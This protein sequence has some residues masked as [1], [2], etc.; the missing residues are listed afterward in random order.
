MDDVTQFVIRHANLVLFAAVFADQ[1]GLPFPSVPVL[2]AAGALAGAGQMNLG[3][4]VGLAV[5]A[6]FVGDFVWYYLGRHRGRHVLN[7]L[8]RISFEPDSCVRHTENFFG[9]HGMRSLILA[10]F[11]PGV[12]TVTPA[13]AGLFN[14]SVERFMLYNGLGALLWTVTYIAPGYLFS[15]QLELIAGQSARFGG[16]LVETGRLS[17]D[18]SEEHTS[19]LQSRLHLVC[20]LLL[21]K[22]KKNKEQT[23]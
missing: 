17:R 3:M 5:A 8:C 23:Q 18:R 11:I 13:L 19:E 6:C 22:K 1:V 12:S 20:R 14:V 2:L 15:D 7:V 9:R 10:K 21:E 16:S 4:A